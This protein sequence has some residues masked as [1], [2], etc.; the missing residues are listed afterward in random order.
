[1]CLNKGIVLID[2]PCSGHDTAE[3][4]ENHYK[5]YILESA[6]I[7]GP[8]SEEWPKFKCDVKDCNQEGVYL[9]NLNNGNY[10][11][12]CHD[13]ANKDSLAVLV[14]VGDCWSS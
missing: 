2:D 7:N 8:K 10:Y 13:H 3:Q 5:Q 12:L 14:E 4:A 11:Q 1:M 9:A 6:L